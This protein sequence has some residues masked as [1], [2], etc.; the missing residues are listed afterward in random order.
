MTTVKDRKCKDGKV[1]K[2]IPRYSVIVEDVLT[3][4]TQECCYTINGYKIV[5]KNDEY[6]YWILKVN[7]KVVSKNKDECVVLEVAELLTTENKKS[8]RCCKC[9]TRF[10]KG[11]LGKGNTCPDCDTTVQA[12]YSPEVK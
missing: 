4:D 8:W 5:I 7:G 3:S 1:Y 12:Y 11:E 9:H 2:T 10:R 6:G